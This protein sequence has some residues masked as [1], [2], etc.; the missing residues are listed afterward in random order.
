MNRRG[1]RLIEF[2]PDASLVI[3][4]ITIQSDADFIFTGTIR[5]SD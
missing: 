3:K 4:F 1:I 5:R 2:E